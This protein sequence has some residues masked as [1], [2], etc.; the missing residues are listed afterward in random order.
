MRYSYLGSSPRAGS[1]MNVDVIVTFVGP[2]GFQYRVCSCRVVL[3]Y[4]REKGRYSEESHV[5]I[6]PELT[7]SHKEWGL[8]HC[9]TH[10][11]AEIGLYEDMN[12]I[13]HIDEKWFELKKRDKSISLLLMR[14]LPTGKQRTNGTLPRSCSFVLFHGQERLTGMELSGMES[15]AFGILETLL[16]HKEPLQKS[17]RHS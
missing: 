13:I 9:V 7:D 1:T 15:L 4:S 8:Q 12:N 11:C 17:S 2:G 5:G 3:L 14:H 16:Q 10:V 6:K